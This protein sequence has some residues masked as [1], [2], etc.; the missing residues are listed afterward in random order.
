MSVRGHHEISLHLVL[1]ERRRSHDHE[2]NLRF[3]VT[4]LEREI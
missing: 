3:L 4:S 1:N 2:T